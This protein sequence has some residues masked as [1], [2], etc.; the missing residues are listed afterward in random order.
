MPSAGLMEMP[1][2][3]NVIPLPTRTRCG[4]PASVPGQ[5]SS[6]NLGGRDEPPP[7]ATTPPNPCSASQFSSR[8]RTSRPGTAFAAFTAAAAS[9]DGSFTFDGVFARSRPN[10][11]AA[12]SVFAFRTASAGR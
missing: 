12:A 4:W 3:S 7:T 8:T 1:P 6:M 2:V 9:H 5:V 10:D 11:V